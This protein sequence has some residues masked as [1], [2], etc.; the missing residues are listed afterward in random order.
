MAKRVKEVATKNNRKIGIML[1]LQ[2]PEVR[3]E[4]KNGLPVEIKKSGVFWIN[5]DFD[6][7]N[8]VIRIDPE[9]ALRFIKKNQDIFIDDGSVEGRVKG[10][11]GR[12]IKIEVE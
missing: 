10:H 2:G 12:G 6:K 3:I 9:T 5:K 11:D 4:T 8:R 7:D 1:D